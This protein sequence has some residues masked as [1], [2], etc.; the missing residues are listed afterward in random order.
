MLYKDYLRQLTS[1]EEAL[2]DFVRVSMGL[3][4]P[5]YNED[6]EINIA[7][8]M[9]EQSLSY[10]FMVDKLYIKGLLKQTGDHGDAAAKLF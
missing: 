10:S 5:R 2:R 3:F 8:S 1:D 6:F 9:I 4:Q 7:E